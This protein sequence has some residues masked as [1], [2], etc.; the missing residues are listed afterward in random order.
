MIEEYG[1]GDLILEKNFETKFCGL[2]AIKVFLYTN[3]TLKDK[4]QKNFF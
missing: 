1:R 2:L 4:V 3:V